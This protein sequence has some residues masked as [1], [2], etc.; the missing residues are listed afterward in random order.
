MQ[1]R[2]DKNPAQQSNMPW[3]A[4]KPLC[5]LHSLCSTTSDTSLAWQGRGGPHAGL[6]LALAHAT[7][8][9]SFNS[10]PFVQFHDFK[11]LVISQVYGI[12]SI[13]DPALSLSS[14]SQTSYDG[15]FQK[16]GQSQTPQKTL[17]TNDTAK[18]TVGAVAQDDNLVP[19]SHR[20]VM[21]DFNDPI[22][23]EAAYV[24]NSPDSN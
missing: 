3:L 11:F 14:S 7:S 12:P 8:L 15:I 13:P 6:A 5:T 18:S 2:G 19:V 24:Y 23:A 22:S 21:N 9:T 1:N 17:K 4:S 20:T 16:F 10:Y